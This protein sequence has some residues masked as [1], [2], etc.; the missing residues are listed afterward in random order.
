MHLP[1]EIPY[2]RL[3]GIWL[4]NAG[5]L[6]GDAVTIRVTSGRLVITRV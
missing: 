1:R 4:I 2:L 3:R 6:P 5:F